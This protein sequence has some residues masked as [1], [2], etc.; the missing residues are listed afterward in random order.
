MRKRNLNVNRLESFYIQRLVNIVKNLGKSYIV[1]QEVFD[2]G[3]KIKP[4][5]VVHVW[6]EKRNGGWR[7]EMSKVTRAGYRT[8]L[9]AP[10]YLEEVVTE[11]WRK[12]YE[13][14]PLDFDGTPQQKKL[15]LGGE[16]CIWGEYA[17]GGNLIN[18]VW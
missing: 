15:V 13:T 16:A 17:D 5:T 12:Y 3:V 1:W 10:W 4:D 8:L 14:D 7:K 6:I 18:K 2:E 11:S 9:S